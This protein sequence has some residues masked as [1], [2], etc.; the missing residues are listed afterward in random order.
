[1][2]EQLFKRY[3][4]L[5]V[6]YDLLYNQCDE[7]FS[8][9]QRFYLSRNNGLYEEVK[10]I[11]S[12]SPLYSSLKFENP[13]E[14]E[15]F[16]KIF[17]YFDVNQRPS[18]CQE[19]K[20]RFP[21]MSEERKKMIEVIKSAKIVALRL[22]GISENG[23]IHAFDVLENKYYD[24]CDINTR[25][26][27]SSPSGQKEADSFYF[28]AIL[29]QYDDIVFLDNPLVVKRHDVNVENRLDDIRKSSYTSVQKELILYT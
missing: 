9:K 10:G 2:D 22:E 8:S 19:L 25:N 3:K 20:T 5:R 13:N 14:I 7:Y 18:I 16:K 17:F 21:S 12:P 23:T 26:N 15:F 1:M 27:L 29:Y 28:C 4:R 6:V 11:N 24:F